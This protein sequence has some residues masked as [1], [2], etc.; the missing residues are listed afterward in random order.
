MGKAWKGRGK[1]CIGKELI[2]NG[3]WDWQGEGW[4][5]KS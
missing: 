2:S 1:G 3:A 5:G 4:V